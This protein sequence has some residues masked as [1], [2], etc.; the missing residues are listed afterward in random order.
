MYL[1]LY[2][3]FT[4][5]QQE[6]YLAFFFDI[7]LYTIYIHIRDNIHLNTLVSHKRRDNDDIF[8]LLL[9]LY[10]TTIYV[11]IKGWRR[12]YAD[13]YITFNFVV[14]RFIHTIT[15]LYHVSYRYCHMWT[16]TCTLFIYNQVAQM[17]RL[18]SHLYFRFSDFISFV[19]YYLAYS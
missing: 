19:A 14:N 9:L 13:D 16:Q 5:E 6:K 12:M 3:H 7:T 2:I 18:Q 8:S 10:C 17:R 11:H 4:L 1:L 15:Y